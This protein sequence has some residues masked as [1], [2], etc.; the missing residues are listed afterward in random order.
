MRNTISSVIEEH[1]LLA[2]HRSQTMKL[3]VPPQHACCT[4]YALY[5]MTPGYDGVKLYA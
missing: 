5:N 3:L 4:M 2:V 1:P